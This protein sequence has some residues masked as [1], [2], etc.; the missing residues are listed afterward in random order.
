M[1]WG[2]NRTAQRWISR[3]KALLLWHFLVPLLSVRYLNGIFQTA[4]GCPKIKPAPLSP[5]VPMG[6]SPEPWEH[7]KM[8]AELQPHVFTE[9]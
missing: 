3:R 4:E 6:C 5:A 1:I 2:Q 8:G 9:E 7:C